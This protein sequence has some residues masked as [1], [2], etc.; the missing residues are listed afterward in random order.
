MIIIKLK[1]HKILNNFVN[2]EKKIPLKYGYKLE[3]STGEEIYQL[4][5]SYFE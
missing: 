4:R 2:E 3:N 5:L 1:Y